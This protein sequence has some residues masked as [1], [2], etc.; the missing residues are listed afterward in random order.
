MFH[1]VSRHDAPF[2]ACFSSRGGKPSDFIFFQH[3][4]A[5]LAAADVSFCWHLLISEKSLLLSRVVALVLASSSDFRSL[6]FRGER[7]LLKK[8]KKQ[9]NPT[10]FILLSG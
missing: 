2:I 3:L 1:W 10:T 7:L 9:K 4:C 5:Y 8:N 6:S